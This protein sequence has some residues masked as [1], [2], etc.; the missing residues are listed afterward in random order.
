MLVRTAIAPP[1]NPN[2]PRVMDGSSVAHK[3]T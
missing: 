1:S 2:R 3:N